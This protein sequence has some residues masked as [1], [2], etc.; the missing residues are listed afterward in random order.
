[1]RRELATRGLI[2]TALVLLALAGAYTFWRYFWFFRDPPRT[3]PAEAGILSPADG[4]VV[5]VKVVEPGAPVVSIKQ[6]VAATLKDI[7]RE[8]MAQRKIVIGIFMS[9]FDVHY[10]RAP[11]AATVSSIRKYPASAEGNVSMTAMHWRSILGLEPRYTGSM[12]IVQNE[13]TVTRLEGEYRGEPTP[14]YVV[15][16]GALTVSGIDSYFSPGQ[17]VGRGETFGM[18]R[19]GSQVDLVVPWREGLAVQVKPGDRVTSGETLLIR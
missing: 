6:G 5:Y 11:L 9:P 3:P 12:H 7:T 10:N 19:V 1:M 18:I 13:R 16:I 14:L 17:S 8:D 15:Q 2:A 4:T